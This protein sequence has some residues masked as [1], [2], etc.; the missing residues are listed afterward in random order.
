MSHI[1]H[2]NHAMSVRLSECIST[3]PTGGIFEKFD[4]CDLRKS[5]RKQNLHA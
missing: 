2:I 3:A 1:A 4:T 5:A